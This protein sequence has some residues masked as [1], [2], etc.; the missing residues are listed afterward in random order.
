VATVAGFA[1]LLSG[2]GESDKPG[3]PAPETTPAHIPRVTIQQP[4]VEPP[5]PPPPLAAFRVVDGD[6][7]KPV[8]RAVVH[9]GQRA[10]RA[11]ANGLAQVSVARL[12]R[13]RV[14]VAARGYQ[15]YAARRVVRRSAPTVIE[16]YRP[17]TQWPQYGAN[18]ARTQAHSAIRLRPPFR[19]VWTRG[20]GGFLEFPA[21]V[22]GGVAYIHNI[23]GWLQAL[24]MEDGRIL[25][26]RRVGTQMASSPAVDPDN[27]LLV[28]AAKHPGWVSV[29]RLRTGKLLW[30]YPTGISEPSPVVR[31]GIAFVA[32]EDGRVH[33][34]D[35]RTRRARWVVDIGAKVTSS[36]ALVGNRLYVGS[37]GG[38]VVCLNARNGRLRWSTG[39]GSR[40]YGTVAVAQGR[41]FVPSVF[42]GLYGLSARSGRI[43]WRVPLG[44]SHSSPAVH[45]GRVFFG[46][47]G[48]TVMA[49]SARTGRVLWSRS[50]G[51]NVAGAVQ[52]VAGLVYAAG[53]TSRLYVFHPRSGRTVW[54]FRFS[55]YVPLSGNGARLLLHGFSRIW[56]VESRRRR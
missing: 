11:R 33:A 36:P 16:V 55:E 12:G 39:V 4:L 26:R 28:S 18:Y 35:L 21:V 44:E 49:V 51:G 37:Y 2:C 29:L 50:A 7:G 20:L 45:G 40:V 13:V 10:A 42:S 38:R 48:G 3:A 34:V 23:K 46:T 31:D 52:V 53:T 43:L 22:W 6:T 19:V 1:V 30:R 25:W 54:S 27:G 32:G 9:V 24:R 15:P 41:V 17:A 5:P 56:A 47:K 8:R 14:R